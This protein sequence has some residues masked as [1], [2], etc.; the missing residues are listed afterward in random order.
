VLVNPVPQS[1][2][3]AR[4]RILSSNGVADC[5]SGTSIL[6][7][8]MAHLH[9]QI[10]TELRQ[11]HDLL[12]ADGTIRPPAQLQGYYDTFRRAFGPEVLRSLEGPELLERMHAHGSRDSLVYWLEFKGDEEFP[13]IFGSIAG[14]SALKFSVYRRAETGTWATKGTGSAPRDISVDEAVEIARR[15]R[16]QLV[17]AAGVLAAMPFV[18]DDNQYLRLQDTLRRVAPDVEDTAWGHKYLTLLFPGLLDD[19]HV[20]D[21]QRYHLVR[22]LQLPPRRGN[23]WAEGRYVCAGRYVAVARELGIPL[24]Q[25]TTL[26]NRRNGTPR[27]YWRVGTT[28]DERVRQKYWRLMRD[29]NLIAVGWQ[30]IGDLSGHAAD[31]EAKAAITEM[32]GRHYPSTPQAI[33]RSGGELFSFVT[34]MAPRDRVVAADGQTV[35]GIGEITGPYSYDATAGFPHQRPVVWRSLAEWKLEEGVRSSVKK[36][37]DFHNLVEIER[38]IVEDEESVRNT[39]PATF[40]PPSSHRPRLPLARLDGARGQLQAVLERKGQA[41]LYGPPG[42]GKTYWALRTARELAS[43]RA[44]GAGFD[45]LDEAGRARIAGT[46]PGG[47]PLVRTTSFHPEYGYEDFIEGY[48]PELAPDGSLTFALVPGVFRKLCG[49]AA[50]EPHLDFYLVVDEINRGDVPRIFGELLTLL[51]QDKRGEAA[52]LAQSGQPFSVPPNVYLIGTMN[53]ADRSIALL[54]VALRRRF[55]FVEL[56]PDYAVLQGASVGGLPLG[57]WLRDLNDRIRSLGGGDARN[58]QVGHAFL[59]AG[60]TPITTLDQ[61]SAVLRDDLVPLLEE[62][63]YDD[64]GQMAEMIGDKLVDADAQRVRR[65]LFEPGRGAE[66]VASLLRP[67]IA[68]AAAAVLGQPDGDEEDEAAEDGPSPD[69]A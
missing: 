30:A 23:A 46:L 15:H 63:C 53:T 55:G 32:V 25:A 49:D 56:M 28:D 4:R 60:G 68:T 65:E 24:H 57:P 10:E 9:P 61:L 7:A 42:T 18:T 36:L 37:R 29:G 51:E 64:F 66:L 13:A 59:L 34:K 3:R 14:G 50:A 40:P 35:L 19:F 17:A 39:P 26:L 33:G 43:L 22:L 20:A 47:R 11:L 45:A 69:T 54:D 1:L 31:Q 6:Q 44:F 8:S 16:D 52:T 27:T 62:Y 58:R 12:S 21:L 2:E 38:R 5:S 41:I 67:E 48:R